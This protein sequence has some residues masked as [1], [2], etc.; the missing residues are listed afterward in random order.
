M[1]RRMSIAS[2]LFA[3][4]T[5]VAPCQQEVPADTSQSSSSQ[6]SENG[7]QHSDESKRIL[8]GCGVRRGKPAWSCE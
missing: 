8:A 5:L 4:S 1:P 2:L 6:V 7:N 3:L